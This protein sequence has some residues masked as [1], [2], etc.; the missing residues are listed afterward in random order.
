M[1][2]RFVIAGGSRGLGKTIAVEAAKQG[3][4]VCLIARGLSDL[5]Q[6]RESISSEVQNH[7]PISIYPADLSELTSTRNV[8][9]AI[10]QEGRPIRALVNCA[11]TWIP[12][13]AAQNL[14]SEDF[15]SAFRLNFFSAVNPT[16]EVLRL[17]QSRQ[18]HPL[19]IVQVGATASLRG[20]KQLAPFCASKTALR[21]YCQS[22]AKELGPRGIHVA[23]VVVDGLIGN[24]R[25]R[26]L[27]PNALPQEF[28]D[29]RSIALSILHVVNQRKDAWT[30][31]WD[32]RPFGETFN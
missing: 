28:M 24:E 11:G 8:F 18:G 10:E 2:S 15:E 13:K 7:A 9:D 30:F 6:A 21:T 25:T 16:Q 29:P 4:A 23:H 32:L 17:H 20:S 27:N 5:E 31:E 19:T 26:G 12:R 1:E 3:F 14:S 22:L